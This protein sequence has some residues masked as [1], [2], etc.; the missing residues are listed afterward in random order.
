MS[1]EGVLRLIEPNLKIAKTRNKDSESDLKQIRLSVSGQQ[2]IEIYDSLHSSDNQHRL[3]AL[4]KA[5]DHSD[6][7]C[8]LKEVIEKLI[9]LQI[10]CD[11]LNEQVISSVTIG[12]KS[13]HQIDNMIEQAVR[14][15]ISI[16]K[17]ATATVGRKVTPYET[18]LITNGWLQKTLRI[19]HA[20]AT[21]YLREYSSDIEQ[22]NESIIM[23]YASRRLL[24]KSAT[25]TYRDY[26][27]KIITHEAFLFKVSQGFNTQGVIMSKAAK[28]QGLPVREIIRKPDSYDLDEFALRGGK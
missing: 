11:R 21:D 13:N 14:Q 17:S 16:N 20:R 10:E 3:L 18:R 8:G 1:K 4:R 19:T 25:D 12:R 6:G 5:L 28:K 22:H 7:Q 24:G 2:L 27:D 15:Q 26:Q 23:D 9:D